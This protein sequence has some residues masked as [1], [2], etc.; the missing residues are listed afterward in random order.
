MTARRRLTKLVNRCSI[1]RSL[2]EYM[3]S[4]QAVRD[5]VRLYGR[6]W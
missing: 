3:E 2:V 4:S 6:P 5:V 1:P